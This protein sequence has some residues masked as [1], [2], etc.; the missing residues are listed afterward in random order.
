M[1]LTLGCSITSASIDPSDLNGRLDDIPIK[2]IFTDRRTLNCLRAEEIETIGQLIEKSPVDLLRI[3]NLGRH[4]LGI[5]AQTLG[6]LGLS[7]GC[8]SASRLPSTRLRAN[9][10]YALKRSI[11]E[12]IALAE[13]VIEFEGMQYRIIPEMNGCYG[14]AFDGDSGVI[15]TRVAL[16]RGGVSCVGFVFQ[17]RS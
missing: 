12:K 17:K 13:R 7:L 4:T 11:A 15:C 2:S 6:S 10:I 3:P 8:N 16:A 1:G 5:I 9:R 14:C